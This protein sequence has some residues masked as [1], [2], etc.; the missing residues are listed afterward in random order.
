MK[1]FRASGMPL[2]P[3]HEKEVKEAFKIKFDQLEE[4][5]GKFNQD[6]SQEFQSELNKLEDELLTKY[7]RSRTIKLK[8]IPAIIKQYNV[9]VAITKTMDGT[10]E[11]LTAYLMDEGQPHEDK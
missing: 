2:N 9:A 5:L 7:P 10:V 4:K 1:L 8:D 6:N 3:K 11:A